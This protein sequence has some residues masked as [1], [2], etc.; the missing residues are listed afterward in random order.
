MPKG[1]RRWQ[2]IDAQYARIE[3]AIIARDAKQLSVVYAPDFEVHTLSSE[4]SSFK[5][6]AAYSTAALE[7]AKEDISIS[8]TPLDLQSCGPATRKVK[9]L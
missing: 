7:Q 4:I 9:V 6:S 5:Q 8:N 3:R 1:H 2:Q